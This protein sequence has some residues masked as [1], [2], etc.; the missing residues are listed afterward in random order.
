MEFF[1]AGRE[2]SSI[3]VR[4][5]HQYISGL[6]NRPGRNG[7]NGISGGTVRHY[8]NALSNLYQ[9]AQS[10]QFVP[11]GFNPVATLVENPAADR[12]VAVRGKG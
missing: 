1:G 2:L 4:D 12:Q 9:R 5:L 8:L 11:P 7:N 10:E 3:T 6:R